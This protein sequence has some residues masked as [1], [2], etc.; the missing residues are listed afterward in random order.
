MNRVDPQAN[1][2]VNAPVR[3]VTAR[4]RF[5][6]MRRLGPNVLWLVAAGAATLGALYVSV[7]CVRFFWGYLSGPG[8]SSDEFMEGTVLSLAYGIC[9]WGLAAILAHPARSAIPRALYIA[10][11]VPVFALGMFLIALVV[12]G[13]V[14]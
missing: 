3:P 8:H 7:S 14:R 1:N 5:H 6:I 2:R 13:V 10:L 12:Y 11:H 9:L 4:A